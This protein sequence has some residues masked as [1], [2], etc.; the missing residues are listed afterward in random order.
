MGNYTRAT[1]LDALRADLADA[2]AFGRP[3]ISNPDLPRRLA[4]NLPLEP[5]VREV[6]YG[7]T[8]AGYI[9]YPT[10]EEVEQRKR[11]AV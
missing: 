9:D 2:I 11:V 3:F 5:A 6:F 10:W 1:A 4:D 7:G 8:D